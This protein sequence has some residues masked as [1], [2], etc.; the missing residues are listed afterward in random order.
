MI[1]GAQVS[2]SLCAC[3]WDF[4]YAQTKKSL[5]FNDDHCVVLSQMTWADDN[6]PIM[7]SMEAQ[8]A[9][10]INP[11]SYIVLSTKVD[12]CHTK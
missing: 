3:E 12:W 11:G 7:R 5:K 1:R 9:I 6:L 4:L 2:A 10:E 8:I